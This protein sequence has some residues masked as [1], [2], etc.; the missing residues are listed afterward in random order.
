MALHYQKTSIKNKVECMLQENKLL[1]FLFDKCPSSNNGW[2]F[3][4]T[5]IFEERNHN[6]CKVKKPYQGSRLRTEKQLVEI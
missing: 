5:I 4:W 1:Y 2:P 3:E 6:G